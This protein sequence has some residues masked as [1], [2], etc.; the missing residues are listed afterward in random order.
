MIPSIGHRFPILLPL[1]VMSPKQGF[2]VRNSSGCNFFLIFPKRFPCRGGVVSTR[3]AFRCLRHV[4]GAPQHGG[5]AL[6]VERRLV[7]PFL[8]AMGLL[9]LGVWLQD[10]LTDCV[11]KLAIV[12][13]GDLAKPDRIKSHYWLLSV[14]MCS[15]PF[16][17]QNLFSP[18]VCRRPSE[19]KRCLQASL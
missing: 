4:L 2:L 17:S 15:F 12:S 14:L 1:P 7:G 9:K 10:P 13:C 11:K 18:F 3:A 8:R 6:S 19:M 16:C 5:V